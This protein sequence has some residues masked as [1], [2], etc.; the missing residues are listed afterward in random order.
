MLTVTE[1]AQEKFLEVVRAQDRDDLSVYL[2]ILGRGVDA[3]AYDIKLVVD[4]SLPEGDVVVHQGD[5]TVRVD[6]E[7]A[8]ELEGAVIDYNLE[9]NG[10]TI[11]NPNPVW[12]DE[13]GREVARVIIEQVNPAVAGHGGAILPVKVQE[14]VVYVRMLGGCQG[15]G[16]AATTL[17]DGVEQAIKAALPQIT[18]VV[19]ITHHA[20]GENPYYPR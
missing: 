4:A 1:Q 3:F 17:T 5:L 7:S 10:F 11:D 6:A 18:D 12:E 9:R 13:V 16:L 19:D 8:P 14:G 15:C 2:R 20:L